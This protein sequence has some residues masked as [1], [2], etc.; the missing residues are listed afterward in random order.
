MGL[1]LYT[2]VFRCCVLDS[3]A[4]YSANGLHLTKAY[5]PN[6]VLQKIHLPS[7]LLAIATASLGGRSDLIQTTLLTR[8]V[9]FVRLSGHQCHRSAWQLTATL[10]HVRAGLFLCQRLSNCVLVPS[11]TNGLTL[12][13]ILQDDISKIP[14][15]VHPCSKVTA[16]T[17][18]PR[19]VSQRVFR[20]STYMKT[21][22]NL[23]AIFSRCEMRIAF[24]VLAT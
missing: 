14:G 19:D 6:R 15:D 21:D 7:G 13:V 12:F 5:F 4:T 16:E 24:L 20:W 11:A 17:S 18:S 8:L 23:V 2:L 9:G 1:C 10:L 3:S 22:L